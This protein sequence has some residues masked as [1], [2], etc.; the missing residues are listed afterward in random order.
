[1]KI[2]VTG[3]IETGIDIILYF[4][5]HLYIAGDIYNERSIF[6]SAGI[7]TKYIVNDKQIWRFHNDK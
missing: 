3:K 1:M 7:I 2:V 4:Y 5:Y 6:S